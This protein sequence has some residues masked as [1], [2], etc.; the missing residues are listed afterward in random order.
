MIRTIKVFNIKKSEEIAQFKV[1]VKCLVIVNRDGI[2]NI[3]DMS[4]NFCTIFQAPTN[5]IY[6]IIL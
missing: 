2:T 6:L 3:E 1:D 5:K 4:K